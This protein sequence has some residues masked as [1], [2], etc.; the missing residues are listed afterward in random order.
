MR[1]VWP[2]LSTINGHTL[3]LE[4]G[5]EDIL[6]QDPGEVQHLK[7]RPVRPPAPV[8]PVDPPEVVAQ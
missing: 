4:P 6:A 2:D 7:V 1:R 3:D 8:T 5:A